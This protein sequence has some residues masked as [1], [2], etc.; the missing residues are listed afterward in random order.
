MG[1]RGGGWRG[2]RLIKKIQN[3]LKVDHPAP[4]ENWELNSCGVGLINHNILNTSL[5]VAG[6]IAH[7][8]QPCWANYVTNSTMVRTLGSVLWLK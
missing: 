7:H 2:E 3:I 8:S 6:A 5:V 4:F 1:G